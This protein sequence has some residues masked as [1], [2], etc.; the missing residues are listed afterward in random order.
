MFSV[1]AIYFYRVP[2]PRA[3]NI[4]ES[5][6]PL[7]SGKTTFYIRISLPQNNGVLLLVCAVSL[8][9]LPGDTGVQ[10]AAAACR[11][12]DSLYPQTPLDDLYLLVLEAPRDNYGAGV[13]PVARRPCHAGF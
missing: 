8:S 5:V 6:A 10:L 4:V 9:L 2:W 3:K 7:P 13:E 11:L 1:P 12:A